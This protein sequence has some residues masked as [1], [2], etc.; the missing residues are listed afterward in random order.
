[1]KTHW[2]KLTNPEYLG[3]YDFQPSEE[4][5][6]TV[7]EIKKAVV[8]GPDG[9]KEECIVCVFAEPFK[10]MVFN[11]TNCKTMKQITGSDF[12]EDWTGKKF[13][14]Y[15]T[16]VK[17]FGATVDALRIKAVPVKPVLEI[18]TPNFDAC[19]KAIKADAANLEKVKQKYEVSAEVE[20]ALSK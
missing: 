9:K 10:P 7:K 5:V 8:T 1:M 11:V 15:V 19:K 14:V 16:A 13:V 18:G 12:I 4:R 17:A 2:K 3:A 6:V 20:A